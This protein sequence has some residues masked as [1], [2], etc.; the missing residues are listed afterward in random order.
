MVHSL[1]NKRPKMLGHWGLL[2]HSK[3]MFLT[4]IFNIKEV[5]SSEQIHKRRWKKGIKTDAE[6]S[7]FFILH[8]C[9]SFQNLHYPRWNPKT[10]IS[11]IH[12]SNLSDFTEL[13]LEPQ[14][15]TKQTQLTCRSSTSPHLKQILMVRLV[16]F[17]SAPDWKLE[18]KCPL[19]LNVRSLFCVLSST[20]N[21]IHYWCHAV[22][23]HH[24][25]SNTSESR[26]RKDFQGILELLLKFHS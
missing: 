22:L 19:Y 5:Q 15:T 2:F 4:V 3:N 6:V 16:E 20:F 10:L 1:P 14:K 8:I 7:Y 17:P 11:D 21:Q 18:V 12:L 26:Q 9:P 13:P 23:K 24:L 25:H